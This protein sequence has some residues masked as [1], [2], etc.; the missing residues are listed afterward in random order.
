[1]KISIDKIKI[2]GIQ[3]MISDLKEKHFVVHEEY[4]IDDSYKDGIDLFK[5]VTVK[6]GK[7]L[8]IEANTWQLAS[9]TVVDVIPMG[10]VFA[11]S[12]NRNL[13]GMKE[14]HKRLPRDKEHL[15]MPP[16]DRMGLIIE[17]YDSTGSR[18]FPAFEL[19]DLRKPI[20]LGKD[21][22]ITVDKPKNTEYNTPIGYISS[23]N[24]IMLDLSNVVNKYAT[25]V[26]K[27]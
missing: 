15:S 19:E 14:F 10:I 7:S 20:F 2:T 25:A 1:M 4:H 9:N 24:N 21:G 26:T 23:R 6:K 18:V 27:N 11:G 17:A 22:E 12:P 16:I 5:I 13:T 8:G 3:E